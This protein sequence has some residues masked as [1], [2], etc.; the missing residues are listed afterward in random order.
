V[1][2]RAGARRRAAHAFGG[3]RAR[4]TNLSYMPWW[5]HDQEKAAIV[6]SHAWRQVLL[7][8]HVELSMQST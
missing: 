8:V 5:L 6:S 3:I 7:H 2:G 4:V 1:A